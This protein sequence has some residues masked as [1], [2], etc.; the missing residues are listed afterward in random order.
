M[1]IQIHPFVYAVARGVMGQPKAI[2]VFSEPRTGLFTGFGVILRDSQS[3][4]R[5]E[6]E[7]K[8]LNTEFQ[9]TP[10]FPRKIARP[11]CIWHAFGLQ[12]KFCRRNFCRR[13]HAGRAQSAI[14]FRLYGLNE[15]L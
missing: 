1:A 14:Q 4:R 3:P 5:A 8:V 9:I 6:K 10:N 15:A 13:F 2:A 7:P 12:V 11:G